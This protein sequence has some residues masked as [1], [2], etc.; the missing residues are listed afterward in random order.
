[1]LLHNLYYIAYKN[2]LPPFEEK[3]DIVINKDLKF[4]FEIEG[5]QYGSYDNPAFI[6]AFRSL[7]LKN[8]K[9]N[10]NG[11]VSLRTGEEVIATGIN[12]ENGGTF[13]IK[14]EKI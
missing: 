13:Q 3:M 4:P 7:T 11:S 14:K 5:K 10:S 8:I 6:E 12:K 9:V 2:D 1:M